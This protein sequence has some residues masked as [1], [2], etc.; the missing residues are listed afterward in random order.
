MFLLDSW[1]NNQIITIKISISIYE[2]KE[3]MPFINQINSTYGAFSVAKLLDKFKR[4]LFI[5]LI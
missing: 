2:D 3:I 1:S 5:F 4:L